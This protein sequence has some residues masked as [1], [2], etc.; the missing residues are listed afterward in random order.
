MKLTHCAAVTA[1]VVLA[2][3]AA[4]QLPASQRFFMRLFRDISRA[5]SHRRLH[6]SSSALQI[7][8]GDDEELLMPLRRGTRDPR[9]V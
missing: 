3:A 9:W 4:L 8:L 7:V 1:L 2:A 5:R 6:G